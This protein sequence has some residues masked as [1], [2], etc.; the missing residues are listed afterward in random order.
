MA[1]EKGIVI[2]MGAGGT[3]TAWVKTLQPSAC[4]GC[5]SRESCASGGSGKEQ[6]VEAINKAGA[7][8]GD[9]IQIYMDSASLLKAAFLLYVF[10]ILCML[11]GG[12]GGNMAS[13]K[14]GM[15][16]SLLS[17]ITAFGSFILSMV[18]VR[19]R[20]GR[21]TLNIE[22]RPKITR[23]IGRQKDASGDSL[24]PGDCAIHVASSI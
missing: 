9:I 17:V 23:I 8:V 6:T 15:D 14:F 11:A 18:L 5:S 1:I 7:Q 12:A 19:I 20:A 2:K 4:K 10:P 22:Y 21:M 24:T 16:A 13:A 3:D